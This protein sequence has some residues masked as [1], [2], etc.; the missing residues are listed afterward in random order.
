MSKKT[1]FVILSVLIVPGIGLL[2]QLTGE[3]LSLIVLYLVPIILAS[4]QGGALWGGLVGGLAIASWTLA[5]LA[6]PVQVDIDPTFL[7]VLELT[8]KLIVFALAAAATTRMR[9]FV[10]GERRKGLT[11]YATGLPNRRAFAADLASRTGGGAVAVGF[12]E[13][14][15]LENLYLERG[16]AFVEALFKSAARLASAAAPTYRFGDERL[17]FIMAEPP[18]RLAAETMRQLAARIEEEL[19]RPKALPLELK[20]GIARC[21]DSCALGSPALRSFLEGGMTFLRS[22]PGPQVESFEFAKN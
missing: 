14:E 4:W 21:R 17:A 3:D 22:R 13:L 15:G 9:A 7:R 19:F 2:D 16:E 6:F 5:N 1:F 12:I 18:G 10:E 8:E 20:I 11:D